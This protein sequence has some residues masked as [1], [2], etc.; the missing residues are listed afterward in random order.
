MIITQLSCLKE[1][2]LHNRKWFTSNINIVLCSATVVPK[3]KVFLLLRLICTGI[4]YSLNKKCK[5]CFFTIFSDITDW[6]NETFNIFPCCITN[7][8]YCKHSCSIYVHVSGFKMCYMK[9]VLNYCTGSC[10]VIYTLYF[11]YK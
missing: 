4:I 11:I 5:K 10:I 6:R 1:C 3:G 7:L 2:V 8:P 9:L